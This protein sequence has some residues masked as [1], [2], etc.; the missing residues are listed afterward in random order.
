LVLVAVWISGCASEK[1]AEKPEWVTP[2]RWP[3]EENPCY[4]QDYLPGKKCLPIVRIRL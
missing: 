4:P 2:E 1:V 3:K